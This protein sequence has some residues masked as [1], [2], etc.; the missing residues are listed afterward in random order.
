MGELWATAHLWVNGIHLGL[1][2]CVWTLMGFR[3]ENFGSVST[4]LLMAA[5]YISEL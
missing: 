3:V 1:L 4:V 2:A 5:Q